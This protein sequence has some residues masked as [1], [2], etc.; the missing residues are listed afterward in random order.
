MY[1]A[2]KRYN[3]MRKEWV[4]NKDCRELRRLSPC[5]IFWEVLDEYDD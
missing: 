4:T 1:L 2:G 3:D 5:A